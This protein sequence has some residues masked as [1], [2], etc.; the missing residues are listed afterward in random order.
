MTLSSQT[1][2]I[3]KPLRRAYATI[4][5]LDR[6]KE[7]QGILRTSQR[8]ELGATRS[9]R[10]GTSPLLLENTTKVSL[11]NLPN[12]WVGNHHSHCP[13]TPQKCRKPVTVICL[14]LVYLKVFKV[15]TPNGSIDCSYQVSVPSSYIGII[16]GRVADNLPFVIHSSLA[17]KE[18]HLHQVMTTGYH[19][20]ILNFE[21]HASIQS[22]F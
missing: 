21:L 22:D 3:R 7:N 9:N 6:I 5:T 19:P 17:Q 20:E 12:N 1:P 14:P 8:V 11:R 4:C 10:Q 18:P 16:C 15:N 13:W 2:L